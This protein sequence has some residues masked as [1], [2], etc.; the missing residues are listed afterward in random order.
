MTL[1]VTMTETC[2]H[3]SFPINEDI[4]S[5]CVRIILNWLFMQYHDVCS[6]LFSTCNSLHDAARA[7]RNGARLGSRKNI[8]LKRQLMHGGAKRRVPISL[9]C[10][11]SVYTSQPPRP[12]SHFTVIT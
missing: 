7:Q 12:M 9:Q 11:R 1:M 3:S 2:I 10:E 6:R 8:Q 4:V 5:L